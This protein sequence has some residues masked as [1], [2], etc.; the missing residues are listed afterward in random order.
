MKRSAQHF[1]VPG[2]SVKRCPWL[3]SNLVETR[4]ATKSCLLP[5]WCFVW[6]VD[7]KLK[8]GELSD[9]ANVWVLMH[10]D[11]V[12]YSSRSGD[13]LDL[14]SEERA[15]RALML[16]DAATAAK[17]LEQA[18]VTWRL[19]ECYRVHP[20][21]M[22]AT[23]LILHHTWISLSSLA[24][25]TQEFLL[26]LHLPDLHCTA[27]ERVKESP[28]YCLRVHSAIGERL[29][30]KTPLLMCSTLNM[31]Q[32]L[33][34]QPD[35]KEALPPEGSSGPAPDDDEVDGSDDEVLSVT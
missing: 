27:A 15:Q 10:V 22:A 4:R 2:L 6:S 34:I 25:I 23:S 32:Q 31:V 24:N 33:G 35:C 8:K 14:S 13:C 21:P 20:E 29:S 3:K 5:C 16:G 18:M 19:Q 1:N 26:G 28:V 12:V 9:L 11:S 17:L 30:K 7:R